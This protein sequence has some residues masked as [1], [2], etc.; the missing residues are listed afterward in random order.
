M[1]GCAKLHVRFYNS[2][3]SQHFSRHAGAKARDGVGGSRHVGETLPQSPL[4]PVRG[5]DCRLPPRL[6]S[7]R[8]ATLVVLGSTHFGVE[9]V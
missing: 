4:S 1:R 5:T 6:R 3:P 8:L 9:L 7:C 2:I